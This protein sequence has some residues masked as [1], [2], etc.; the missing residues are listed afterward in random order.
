[1]TTIDLRNETFESIQTRITGQRREVLLWLRTA[2]PSTTRRLAAVSR[3]DILSVR[4]RITELCQLGLAAL[5]E[6]EGTE[7]IYEALREPDARA[8]FEERRQAYITGQYQPELKL[9]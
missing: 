3:I 8:L 6:Q 7:G 1:M 5:V 2:G 9:L 4:P